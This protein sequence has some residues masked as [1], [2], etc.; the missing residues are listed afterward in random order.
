MPAT[1][2][3]PCCP[4]CRRDARLVTGRDLFAHRPDLADLMFWSCGRCDAYVGCHRNSPAHKPLG[5]LADRETRQWRS[6]AHE[7]FDVYW[8][9]GSMS[10]TQAYRLLAD[11]LRLRRGRAHISWMDAEQ[12]QAVVEVFNHPDMR[13]QL[14]AD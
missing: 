2:R 3:V 11:K 14:H 1:T 8:K 12:C 7:A 9:S 10:R 5:S 4:Y 13:N 6:R